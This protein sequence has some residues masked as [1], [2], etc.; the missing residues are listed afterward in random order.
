MSSW[1]HSLLTIFLSFLGISNN[2]ESLPLQHHPAPSLS[3]PLPPP[4]SCSQEVPTTTVHD[5]LLRPLMPAAPPPHTATIICHQGDFKSPQNLLSFHTSSNS[6]SMDS[7]TDLSEPILFILLIQRSLCC[8]ASS[9]EEK[10]PPGGL[11]L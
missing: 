11:M 5:I 8:I 4:R 2:L 6:V 7:Q 9:G 3:S 1:P 10:M